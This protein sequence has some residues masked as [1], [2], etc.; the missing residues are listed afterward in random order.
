MSFDVARKPIDNTE[1]IDV[2]QKKSTIGESVSQAIAKVAKVALK[3]IVALGIA[4]TL[5]LPLL[6]KS[7]RL[8]TA[9]LFFGPSLE[10]ELEKAKI[11]P[12]KAVEKAISSLKDAQEAA[13]EEG[14]QAPKPEDLEDQKGNLKKTLLG[15]EG[16]EQNRQ[17]IDEYHRQIADTEAVDFK[18]EKAEK[19]Q[20]LSEYAPK[21][22]E[23]RLEKIKLDNERKIAIGTE[24]KQGLVLP[25]ITPDILEKAKAKKAEAEKAEAEKPTYMEK[26]TKKVATHVENN[27]G[28]YAIALGVGA[29]LLMAVSRLK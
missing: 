4:L 11:N 27:S 15:I 29:T 28:R 2:I 8:F 14:K 7:V 9:D 22:E 6:S 16:L 18:K 25:K 5:G 12:K 24:G 21:F 26:T 19:D 20:F 1:N 23:A 10:R 17:K 3:A 13:K